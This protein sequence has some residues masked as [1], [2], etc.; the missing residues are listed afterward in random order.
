MPDRRVVLLHS[1]LGDSRL[2]AREVELLRKRGYDAVAP[3]L[4]GFGG[5]PMPHERFSF[6]D[7]VAELLPAALVGNSFGGGIGRASCRE[8]V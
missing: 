3:D 8:R 2:W 1:S 5:E 4:P 6:V 7:P